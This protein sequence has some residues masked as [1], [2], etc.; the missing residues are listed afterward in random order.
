MA[1]DP[2]TW[3]WAEPYETAAEAIVRLFFPHVEAVI[4]DIEQDV[5]VRIWNPTS[6]RKPGDPSLLSAGL[7]RELS[8]GRVTGPY[9]QAGLRGAEVS[10]VSAVIAD[11]RGLLCLNFDRS[12]ISAAADTLRT[13]ALG[14]EPR[15]AGLF[16]RDWRED[17]NAV[18]Q[19][20]CTERGLRVA[21]LSRDDRRDLVAHLDGRGA[22][23]VRRAASHLAV[24]LGVSRATIYATLRSA[25]PDENDAA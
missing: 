22:F 10:S 4:H 8:R 15:P 18:V 1:E 9:A 23:A 12:A 7:L 11:G 13:F 21:H 3:A 14:V 2:P 16:E 24:I 25:R 19:D 6:G 20:W 17:L 5:V